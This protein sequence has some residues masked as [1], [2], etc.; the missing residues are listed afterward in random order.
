MMNCAAPAL[1]RSES[2][3]KGG[4]GGAAPRGSQCPIGQT[5]AF[6]SSWAICATRIIPFPSVLTSP[7]S[8]QA[9]SLNY[10]EG[11]TLG[12][13][14]DISVSGSHVQGA[15]PYIVQVIHG[16]RFHRAD[17]FI[18]PLWG[19]GQ[20][21]GPQRKRGPHRCPIFAGVFQGRV[22]VT[23]DLCLS[24]ETGSIIHSRSVHVDLGFPFVIA[25]DNS[26][27]V[28][29]ALECRNGQASYAY[30][31]SRSK[32]ASQSSGAIH[33]C[34]QKARRSPGHCHGAR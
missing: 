13:Q 8:C 30:R 4:A 32:R 15:F 14:R 9:N 29:Y 25:D 5:S 12:D 22:L 24:G 18:K 20:R 33:G 11:F 27:V 1:L 28:A 26:G 6:L 10:P 7:A 21:G 23:P 2:A 31:A 34:A 3:L 16:C 19:M 17:L